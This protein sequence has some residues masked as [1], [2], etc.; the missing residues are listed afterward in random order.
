MLYLYINNYHPKLIKLMFWICPM[1]GLILCTMVYSAALGHSVPIETI[2][3]LLLG[4]LF[5]VIGNLMPKCRY[6]YTMGIKL[7]WTLN[8]DENWNATHRFAGKVWVLC[9]IIALF[10]IFLPSRASMMLL[11]PNFSVAALLPVAYSYA[12]HKKQLKNGTDSKSD[13]T[14]EGGKGSKIG[15]VISVIVVIAIL[16]LTLTI[17]FACPSLP[18]V[19]TTCWPSGME[20]S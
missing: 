18:A 15:S 6:S 13:Q 1:I 8:S 7:P 10:S 9:G 5:V 17:C 4:V 12:F 14:S 11:I 3:P 19:K 16:V 2:M 20:A